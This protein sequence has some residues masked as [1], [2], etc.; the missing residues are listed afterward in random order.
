MKLQKF[1]WV[2][3]IHVIEKHYVPLLQ[4][5]VEGAGSVRDLTTKFISIW[6]VIITT[7]V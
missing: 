2:I 5:L 3:V 6:K 1:Q 4:F 7:I